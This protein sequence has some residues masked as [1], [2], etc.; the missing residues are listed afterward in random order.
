MRSDP[1][2]KP[3]LC[4]P[5]GLQV[6]ESLAREQGANGTA[7]I[8][9]QPTT[10]KAPRFPAI[11]WRG[12]FSDYIQAVEGSTEAS[13]AA[14][15]ASLWAAV[16][17]ALGRRVEMFSG[18]QTYPNV[19]LAFFGG[20]GDKKTTAMRSIFSLLSE[21]VLLIPSVGSTEGLIELVKDKSETRNYD[22]QL[23]FWEEFSNLLSRARWS[24]ST[25]LEFLAETFDCPDKWELSYRKKNK[26]T[27]ESPT[28]SIICG[29]TAEWFWKSARPEDFH[30]GFGNRFLFLTGERKPP[31][32]EPDE[33]D[34]GAL[35]GIRARIAA[36]SR[37]TPVRARWSPDA[38]KRW[39]EFYLDWETRTREPLLAAATKRVHVYARKMAMAYAA[40]EGTLPEITADQARAAIAVALYAANCAERLIDQ[41]IRNESDE[42]ELEQRILRWAAKNPGGR[43][44]YLQ[45][46]MSKHAT[47]IT[48]NKVLTAL[49][50]ADQIRIERSGGRRIWPGE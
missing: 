37:I 39:S 26:V 21:S 4:G 38:R 23:Y 48:F 34:R 47:A 1:T 24:G 19:Y 7:V 30:G 41:R 6:I 35:A 49:E 11:A 40:V 46:V 20:T 12:I 2:A 31:I 50:H 15:F 3:P 5:E 9:E 32:P 18:F 14:H 17:S 44:R 10:P 43:V 25:L 22:S 16:A 28:P 36:L 45:Q 8:V 27:I 13:D 29:T 42:S 33:P